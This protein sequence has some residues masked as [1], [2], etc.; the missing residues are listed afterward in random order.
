MTLWRDVTIIIFISSDV[1]RHT[2]TTYFLKYEKKTRII[3]TALSAMKHANYRC[4]SKTDITIHTLP[5]KYMKTSSH[6]F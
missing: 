4:F 5:A 1:E 3:F 6:C 2:S